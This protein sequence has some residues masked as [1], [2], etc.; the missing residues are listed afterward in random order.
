MFTLVKRFPLPLL[1]ALLLLA[2]C[3][4]PA[5]AAE[6]PEFAPVNSGNYTVTYANTAIVAD[7][8]YLLI[9]V[10]GRYDDAD[11]AIR[12]VDAGGL[13]YVNQ[14]GQQEG[15]A[16]A[17]RV[18]F[19][20]FQ[21]TTGQAGEHTLLLSG[22]GNKPILI[23]YLKGSPADNVLIAGYV[24][25]WHFNQTSTPATLT[26]TGITDPTY[27]VTKNSGTAGGFYFEV[28]KGQY[29]LQVSPPGGY[30]Y[31]ASG[32]KVT[33]I[34]VREAGYTFDQ[35]LP[36]YAGDFDGDGQ[37]T[38]DDLAQL[39][40]QVVKAADNNFAPSMGDAVY[41]LN[42]DG[43]YNVSDVTALLK[44]YMKKTPVIVVAD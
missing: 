19:S 22:L 33:S 29:S 7:G 3:A 17:G 6:L 13:T 4:A 40:I 18:T 32:C 15:V 35:G 39:V 9:A 28:P 24:D 25:Y 10:A 27:T 16:A 21:P 30:S 8:H 11:A 5:L 44:G 34:D 26:L 23:G 1:L 14:T 36:L 20:N 37:I 38:P 12:S 31:L 42:G 2:L 43:L 41:D